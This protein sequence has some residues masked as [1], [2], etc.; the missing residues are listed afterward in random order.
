MYIKACYK[1]IGNFYNI[2]SSV[3]V[4]QIYPLIPKNPKTTMKAIEEKK[5]IERNCDVY[6]YPQ[7]SN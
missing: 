2:P 5:A 6:I 7:I 4:E 3:K 1:T